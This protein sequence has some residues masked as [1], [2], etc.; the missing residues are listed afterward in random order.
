MDRRTLARVKQRNPLPEGTF[1]VGVGLVISGLAAYAYLSLSR[2]RT[3]GSTAFAP[4]SVLWFSTFVLAPGFFL[5]VEQEVGRALAHRRALLQGGRPLVRKAFALGLGMV[6]V[7][8]IAIVALGPFLV[9][10]LFSGYWTLV[11]ALLIA[12]SSYAAGH[13]PAACSGDRPVQGL[14]RVHG[15]RRHVR[16]LGVFALAAA[17]VTALLPYG[18]LVGIPPMIAVV[19]ALRWPSRPALEPARTRRGAS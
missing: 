7:I 1:A 10:E 12:F 11:P 8:S 5:P 16:V 6:V 18:L 17:G 19:V 13:S 15:H 9:R 14:R 4:V 3:L 2:C